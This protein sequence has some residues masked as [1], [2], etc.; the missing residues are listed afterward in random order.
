M[1]EDRAEKRKREREES[2]EPSVE[3]TR[4]LS[5]TLEQVTPPV[6][7]LQFSRVWNS[8][9][10]CL[11]TCCRPKRWRR[12][13]RRRRRARPPSDG[14]SSTKTLFTKVSCAYVIKLLHRAAVTNWS[15]PAPSPA[16]AH[17]KRLANVKVDLEAYSEAKVPRMN[18]TEMSN[19]T[20]GANFF[21]L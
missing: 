14:I 1:A 18:K 13:R 7:F 15:Y 17:K 8:A 9:S 21:L 20:L 19:R 6:L 4:V 5:V 2:G 16:A 3:K 11:L 12:R 10:F